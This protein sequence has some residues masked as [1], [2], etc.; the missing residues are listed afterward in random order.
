MPQLNR[1]VLIIVDFFNRFDFS[2][3]PDLAP[4]AL[5]AARNT[6]ALK[7]RLREA[8]VRTIYANDNFGNWQ[9]EFSALVRSCRE[10]DGPP[11]EIAKLLTPEEG[12]LSVLKPR[13]S[14][15]YGT[16]LEFLLD[17]LGSQTLVITGIAADSCITATAQDAYVR[18][19]DLW[20]PRDCIAAESPKFTQAAVEHMHRIFKADVDESVSPISFG[21]ASKQSKPEH[22]AEP[23]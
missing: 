23:G 12:D 7:K 3:G 14:A 22:V 18:K 8:N 10:L 16:P 2:G 19:F 5:E 11:G 13:H 4:A 15:F 17:E 1:A 20:I 21:S 6:A 9:S